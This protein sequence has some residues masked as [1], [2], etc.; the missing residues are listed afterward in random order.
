MSSYIIK[1]RRRT[2]AYI[3][4]QFAKGQLFIENQPKQKFK[5]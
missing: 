4:L 5:H 3:L 1:Q 2:G